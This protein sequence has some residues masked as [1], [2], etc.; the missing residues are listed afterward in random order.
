MNK[1]E[2]FVWINEETIEGK[3]LNDIIF[4]LKHNMGVSEEDIKKIMKKVVE[5]W[6]RIS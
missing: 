3:P 4:E 5:K 1:K 2:L 6:A